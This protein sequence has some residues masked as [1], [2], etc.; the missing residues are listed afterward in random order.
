MRSEKKNRGTVEGKRGLEGGGE[1]GDQSHS[2]R[3]IRTRNATPPPEKKRAPTAIPEGVKT[4]AGKNCAVKG[5]K[6]RE[7]GNSRQKGTRHRKQFR[8]SESVL[9]FISTANEEGEGESK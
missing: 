8:N 2:H 7:Q 5:K 6:K 3:D 1:K 9:G 4:S